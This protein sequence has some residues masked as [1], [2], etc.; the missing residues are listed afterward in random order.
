MSTDGRKAFYAKLN[1]EC[2]LMDGDGGIGLLINN[3]GIA[4]E[5]PKQLEEFSDEEVDSI[6][7]CNIFSTVYMTRIVMKYM[8][9]KKNGCIISISSISGNHVGPYLQIYSSTKAFI[10]QFSR[11]MQVEAWGTG[12]DFLVVTPYYIVSNL[13]KRKGGTLLAPMPDKLVTGTLSQLGKRYVWQG[14]GYWFHGVLGFFAT[15]YWGMADRYRKMM[16][17]NRKRYDLKVTSKEKG[18]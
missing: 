6:I 3:V 2:V 7:N 5:Y 18:N 13:Y 9:E 11:S 4:N 16:I 14:H 1:E 10:T 17:D 15:Y 12:V 8:K